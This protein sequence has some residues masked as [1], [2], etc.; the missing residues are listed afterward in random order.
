MTKIYR[1]KLEEL[2]KLLGEASD[3]ARVAFQTKIKD[4]FIKKQ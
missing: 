3:T 4:P 2:K 1:I